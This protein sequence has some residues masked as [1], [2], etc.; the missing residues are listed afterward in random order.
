MAQKLAI[1]ILF[2]I[3]IVVTAGVYWYV[4][5]PNAPFELVDTNQPN[6]ISQNQSAPSNS[7][8]AGSGSA[9]SST[10][11]MP[12]EQAIA[13]QIEATLEKIKVEGKTRRLTSSEL[14]Y[15]ANPRDAALKDL[16][17]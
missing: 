11:A 1:A 5:Q 13:A 4:S 9:V 16:T 15:L 7:S 3:L 17:K 2:L 12:S 10:K 8:V 14:I 6:P